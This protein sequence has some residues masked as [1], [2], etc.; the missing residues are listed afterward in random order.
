MDKI[1]PEERQQIT[2]QK[3]KGIYLLGKIKIS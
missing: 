3:E 1:E 2:S